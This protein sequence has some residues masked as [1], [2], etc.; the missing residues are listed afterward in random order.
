MYSYR[1]FSRIRGVA[2]VC[3][4]AVMMC[5]VIMNT[6]SESKQKEMGIIVKDF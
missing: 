4:I 5:S 1:E 3:V 2:G 6:G